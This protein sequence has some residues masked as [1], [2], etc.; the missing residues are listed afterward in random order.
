MKYLKVCWI[1]DLSTEPIEMFSELDN[2][3][4]E[5]RKVEVFADG[6]ATYADSNK[7]TGTSRLAEVPL[8]PIEEIAMDPQFIPMSISREEFE[9]VWA[10]ATNGEKE[11]S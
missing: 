3:F 8:P 4:W 2:N 11:I 9:R 10:N 6:T 7:S 5:L 1:H